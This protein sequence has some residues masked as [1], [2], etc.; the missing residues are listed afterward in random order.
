MFCSRCG[1]DTAA[2]TFCPSCGTQVVS[3]E[4]TVLRAP[5]PAPPPAPLG[6]APAST[7]SKGALM[8]IA[9][10]L[11]LLLLIGMGGMALLMRHGPT[12]VAQ[13]A[14]E[15]R[16]PAVRPVTPA[17]RTVA[18]PSARHRVP[19]TGPGDVR[20][21]TAGLFCR[22][23][24]ARGYSYVAAVDYWRSHGEPNQMDAD[25]NGIPCETVYPAADVSA[26][27]SVRELPSTAMGSGVTLP[28]GLMCRDLYDQGVPYPRA[29]AYWWREG[30]PDR[31]DADRNG[32][33]CETV[34]PPSDIGTYW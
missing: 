15:A 34:Y 27:W 4:R 10:A 2:A 22:D 31:M 21:L 30:A 6:V 29:V 32:V 14:R 17:P 19:R 33:P 20:A 3:A 24:L 9:V 25:R 18:R 23:L 1:A 12:P 8:P 13:L 28:S 11:G 7:R 26:Y 5:T 16:S